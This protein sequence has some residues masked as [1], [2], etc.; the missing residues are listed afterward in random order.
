MEESGQDAGFGEHPVKSVPAQSYKQQ[1][2]HSY[3]C[4]VEGVPTHR[5]V[6]A[7]THTCA[8]TLASAVPSELRISPFVFAQ[9]PPK[10]HLLKAAQGGRR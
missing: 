7:R 3:M 9:R 1:V 6:H 5:P 4:S 8:S 2:P 10:C